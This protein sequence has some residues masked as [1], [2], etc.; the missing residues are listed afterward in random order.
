MVLP[1]G[2]LVLPPSGDRSVGT[3]RRKLALTALHSLLSARSAEAGPAGPALSRLQGFLEA[4]L[5]SAHKRALVS[6]ME[7]VDVLVPLLAAKSGITALSAALSTSVPAMLVSLARSLPADFQL[8]VNWDFPVTQ[9]FDPIAGWV[10]H[11]EEPALGLALGGSAAS[12]HLATGERF[13]LLGAAPPPSAPVREKFLQP[14][15]AHGGPVLALADSNPLS[16]LEEHPDKSGNQL[17]LGSRSVEDWCTTLRSALELVAD[18]IPGLGEEVH[19]SLERIVPVGFEPERHYSAS[20]REGPGLIYMTLHPSLLT[21]AEAIVHET[22]HGKLNLLRWFDPLL[23]NGDSVWTKSEVRPDLRPLRGVLL[24]VH[25]FVPVAALHHQLAAQRHPLADSE[26]FRR[27]RQEVLAANERGLRTVIAEGQ[28]S[29]LG[30][31]VLTGLREL[32]GFLVDASP[33]EVASGDINR[34]G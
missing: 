4:V 23:V 3:L 12:L 14:L 6:V 28:P 13:D 9:V 2:F 10:I 16:S 17:D 34:L 30:A 33:D 25:A 27:R 19:A 31:R 18:A 32:H 15:D 29:E 1:I 22:Q 5:R 8:G 20:Y 24:A 11:C 7:R 26:V 21:M